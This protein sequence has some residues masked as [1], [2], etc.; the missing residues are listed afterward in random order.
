M[1]VI[2]HTQLTSQDCERKMT[3]NRKQ[4]NL[5][6]LLVRI[7]LPV[8][9][10]CFLLSVI[11]SDWHET[12]P[13]FTTRRCLDP[14]RLRPWSSRETVPS[15][16]ACNCAS[17][18]PRR[19]VRGPPD[20]QRWFTGVSPLVHQAPALSPLRTT[21]IRARSVALSGKR[22]VACS[23]QQLRRDRVV[24]VC[25]MAVLKEMQDMVNEQKAVD[26]ALAE[27]EKSGK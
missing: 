18:W 4:H 11:D 12:L 1:L 24:A 9:C 8:S 15:L 25:S 16:S 14:L 3:E 5:A 2:V 20:I 13:V 10:A 23:L 6:V 27:A 22:L 19:R 17:S 26:A 21:M 7:D